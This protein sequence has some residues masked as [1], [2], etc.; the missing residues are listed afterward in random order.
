MI[1]VREYRVV[2][3][4]E[5]A[6]ELNQKRPN[7]VVAGNMWLRLGKGQA[8]TLIDISRLGLDTIEETDEEFVI[9]AMV[10]LRELETNTALNAFADGAF[11]E[12]VRH[13]I[14]VQFRNL[15]TVGGSIFGRFGF[16]D[17]LTIFLAMDTTVELYKGGMVPLEEF[18][19][20]KRDRD[21]LLRL[22]VRKEKARYVYN[23][24]RTNATTDFPVLTG[25]MA[26]LPDHSY[27]LVIGA[28]PAR[29]VRLAAADQFKGFVNSEDTARKMAEA[30]RD[31]VV[32]SGNLRGSAEYR[33]HLTGV[34]VKRMMKSLRE[35]GNQE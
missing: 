14:G 10:P 28:R 2:E 32:T 16:S 11:R 31:E 26:F 35:G 6:W 12:A 19:K 33:K 15:A 17:V 22:H 7:R 3:S 29:A 4:V 34:V 25:A 5:E 27:R 23:S 20:M 8:G 9:G 13:I 24:V 18:A 30:A 21:I 1:K